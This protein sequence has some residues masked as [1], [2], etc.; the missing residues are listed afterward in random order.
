MKSPPGMCWVWARAQC[1]SCCQSRSLGTSWPRR[2]ETRIERCTPGSGTIRSVDL[3]IFDL[4]IQF[5]FQKKKLSHFLI[6]IAGTSHFHFLI[7]D[8]KKSILSLSN[9]RFHFLIKVCRQSTLSLSKFNTKNWLQFQAIYAFT[10][11][12]E[13]QLKK[14]RALPTFT[15]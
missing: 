1:R 12:L 5:Q 14:L 7:K 6:K 2:G 3:I 10:F 15:F 9:F 4:R 8:G 11:L 13:M